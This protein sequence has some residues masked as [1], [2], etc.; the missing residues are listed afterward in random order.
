[1]TT[2][3][4]RYQAIVIDLLAQD[5]VNVAASSVSSVRVGPVPFFQGAYTAEEKLA[6]CLVGKAASVDSAAVA[7]AAAAAID[8]LVNPAALGVSTNMVGNNHTTWPLESLT[9]EEQAEALPQIAAITASTLR[10]YARAKTTTTTTTTTT[11]NSVEDLDAESAAR[12]L[13]N[14]LLALR[15]VALAEFDGGPG[16]DVTKHGV[17][18]SWAN[19]EWVETPQGAGMAEGV[20]RVASA[21]V[22]AVPAAAAA[23]AG[24]GG[25]QEDEDIREVLRWLHACSASV[26]LAAVVAGRMI[27]SPPGEAMP[28]ATRTYVPQRQDD[29]A[30]GVRA[31]LLCGASPALVAATKMKVASK[32]P[33]A[34]LWNQESYYPGDG[35]RAGHLEAA[36]FLAGVALVEGVA[37]A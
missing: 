30:P 20:R 32:L 14:C 28:Y 12:L 33:E 24:G 7:A 6:A 1:M 27:T 4:N 11:N 37:R 3:S 10:A 8:R 35:V 22:A 19:E 2:P 26:L 29:D 9:G 16:P 5:M 21:L 23:A 36:A 15:A 31:A 18:S 17:S 13:N 34:A 25:A